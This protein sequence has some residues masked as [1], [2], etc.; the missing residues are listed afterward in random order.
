MKKV[1]HALLAACVMAALSAIFD[2]VSY[3]A[4]FRGQPVMSLCLCTWDLVTFGL[5]VF[6]IRGIKNSN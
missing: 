1:K 3:I 6:A 4:F 5:I 2:I